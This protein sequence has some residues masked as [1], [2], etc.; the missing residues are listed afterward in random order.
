MDLYRKRFKN[1]KEVVAKLRPV[2]DLLFSMI[3]KY[4]P[5]ILEEFLKVIL[6][7]DSL[8]FISSRIQDRYPALPPYK[9]VAMDFTVRTVDGT[10][11]D[12]E[13]QTSH[14]DDI[15][16]KVRLYECKN[17][18]S[19]IL[20]GFDYSIFPDGITVILANKDIFGDNEAVYE[21]YKAVR[22]SKKEWIDG[23][24]IVVVNGEYEGDDLIGDYIHDFVSC[25]VEDMR[26]DSVRNC[27]KYFKL[28]KERGFENMCEIIE[29]YARDETREAIEKLEEENKTKIENVEADRNKMLNFILN[30]IRKGVLNINDASIELGIPKTELELMI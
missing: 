27:V 20:S 13:A 6:N 19:H 22:N 16:K 24:K 8:K 3:G 21:V 12:F 5:E 4:H 17:D 26:L 1:A 2:D 18:S 30:Q 15:E 11:I 10:F 9:S 23:R 29:Q 25:D 14:L 28:E 7:N